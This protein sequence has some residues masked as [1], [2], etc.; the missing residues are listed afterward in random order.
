MTLLTRLRND[1]R[2]FSLPDTIVAVIVSA[3]CMT[4]IV[5]GTIAANYAKLSVDVTANTQ[6]QIAAAQTRWRN[7]VDHAT[8]IIPAV[9][10]VKFSYV[11]T[12]NTCVTSTWALVAKKNITVTQTNFPAGSG[13][14][15]TGCLGTETSHATETVIPDSGAADPFSYRNAGGRLFQW[16][17]A[18]L[19]L[20]AK[21]RDLQV[22]E[23]KW[24]STAYKSAVLNTTI[25]TSTARPV[26]VTADQVANRVSILNGTTSATTKFVGN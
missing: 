24:E 8:V 7:D 13:I 21:T 16:S 10:Q 2:G 12:D 25:N 22:S 19:V 5:G 15:V 6:Q 17:G 1:Q 4:A 14:G 20:E 9:E 23:V 3:L 26:T 18:N 11:R